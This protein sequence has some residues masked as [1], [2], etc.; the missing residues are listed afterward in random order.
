[1]H[2]IQRVCSKCSLGKIGIVGSNSQYWE[3]YLCVLG[4]FNSI[5]D[6]GERKG[7]GQSEDLNDMGRCNSFIVD[8]NL[9][10]L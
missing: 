6:E 10:E 9:T 5:R 1:M 7:R 3:N 2:N 8:S 4:D